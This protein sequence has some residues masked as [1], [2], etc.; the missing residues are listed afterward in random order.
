M[1]LATD[2]GTAGREAEDS[3]VEVRGGRAVKMNGDRTEKTL[4]DWAQSSHSSAAL[5]VYLQLILSEVCLG[6]GQCDVTSNKALC[7]LILCLVSQNRGGPKAWIR[8]GVAY[9]LHGVMVR[10]R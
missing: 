2:H 8:K 6:F 9:I 3:T 5:R 7:A 1:R 4:D 10:T